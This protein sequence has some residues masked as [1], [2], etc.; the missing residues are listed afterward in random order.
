MFSGGGKRARLYVAIKKLTSHH[1]FILH[2]IAYSRTPLGSRDL[3]LRLQVLGN[4]KDPAGGMPAGLLPIPGCTALITPFMPPRVTA[5]SEIQKVT[6]KLGLTAQRATYLGTVHC[7]CTLIAN[8]GGPGMK[9]NWPVRYIGVSKLSCSACYSWI[10]AYNNQ[11]QHQQRFFTAGTHGKWYAQWTIPAASAYRTEGMFT[12]MIAVVGGAYRTYLTNEA[13]FRDIM[14]ADSTDAK[15]VVS[16]PTV[17]V[18][19]MQVKKL[20]TTRERNQRHTPT[21]P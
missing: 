2:L 12:E 18:A 16:G 21:N 17:T 9:K 19:M 13:A 14:V 1:R 8:L 11:H 15:G 7:E 20:W 3:T 10:Q 4:P 5:A 6:S